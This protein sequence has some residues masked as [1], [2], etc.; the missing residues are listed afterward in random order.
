M[1][2]SLPS[3]TCTATGEVK[4]T[5]SAKWLRTFSRSWEFHAFTQSSAKA[6]ASA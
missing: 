3:R 4:T 5:L 1:T 6:T 2:P